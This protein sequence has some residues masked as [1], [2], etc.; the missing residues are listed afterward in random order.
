MLKVTATSTDGHTSVRRATDRSVVGI[1]E[2]GEY[3]AV[4]TRRDRITHAVIAWYFASEEDAR[5]CVHEVNSGT[6]LHKGDQRNYDAR[7][8]RARAFEVAGEDSPIPRGKKAVPP[9][10]YCPVHNTA[11]P[12]NG[13]CDDCS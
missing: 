2:P 12:A 5:R 9:A 1:T 13:R 4:E 7:I 8:V 11:L 10:R 6:V 3:W